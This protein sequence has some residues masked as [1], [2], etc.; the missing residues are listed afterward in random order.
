MAN[1]TIGTINQRNFLISQP[2]QQ[3]FSESLY[4]S[5]YQNCASDGSNNAGV[6]PSIPLGY[7]FE[8]ADGDVF[9][10]VENG[11]ASAFA[12][13]TVLSN[14]AAVTM[15]ACSTSADGLTI[16]GTAPA[17]TQYLN[18]H[19][20]SYAYISAGTGEGVTRRIVA[21]S[22]SALSTAGMT[23]TLD[24]SIGS[25]LSSLTVII[26]SK[27]RMRA[28]PAGV[29]NRVYGVSFGTVSAQTGSGVYVAGGVSYYGWMQT[30]GHC[31]KVLVT[32]A[33]PAASTV[34][35]LLT[36]DASVAGS[37]V[38]IANGAVPDDV[39][40]FAAVANNGGATY[41]VGVPADLM[42]LGA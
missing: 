28:C 35:G 34:N 4:D 2:Y 29:H 17:A 32:A 38:G 6:L 1:S 24:A 20:G 31:R 8:T 16:T 10:F 14:I 26:Y 41:D 36:P 21:N 27:W 42:I 39:N 33:V 25:S 7:R 3:L 18:E 15:T 40:V 30:R 23:V 19:F 9:R 5:R 13:G 12:E 11:S 22:A 37:A